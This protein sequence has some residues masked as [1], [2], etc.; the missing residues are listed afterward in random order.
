MLPNYTY[1]PLSNRVASA[2]LWRLR[3][4]EGADRRSRGS[5]RDGME[6]LLASDPPWRRARD[7]GQDRNREKPK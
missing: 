4:K 7:H 1:V 5:N 3:E 2:F 6:L